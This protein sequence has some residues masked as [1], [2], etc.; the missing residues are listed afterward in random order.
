MSKIRDM[1]HKNDREVP[2]YL[3]NNIRKTKVYQKN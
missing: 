2:F 3:R 1:V